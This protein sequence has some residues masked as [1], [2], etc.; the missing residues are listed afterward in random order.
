[1]AKTWKP[2]KAQ[3]DMLDFVSHEMQYVRSGTREF[4]T[5]QSLEKRG[6][7][8]YYP[9]QEYSKN[10]G[11][12]GMSVWGIT[13]KGKPYVAEL[14]AFMVDF[15]A[16]QNAQPATGKVGSDADLLDEDVYIDEP[17][18]SKPLRVVT[19]DNCCDEVEAL[20]QER[21]KLLRSEDAYHV[22]NERL[23]AALFK[24]SRLIAPPGE[25]IA[26]GGDGYI[27]RVLH[28]IDE[29]LADE[30]VSGGAIDTLDKLE[31]AIVDSVRILEARACRP[32][33]VRIHPKHWYSM[34]R[35]SGNAA[36][37]FPG[38]VSVKV[39]AR[40]VR[41]FIELTQDVTEGSIDVIQRNR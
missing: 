39:G 5:M 20:I 7:V 29:A 8:K 33:H 22:E 25:L 38:A 10:G 21:D 27:M 14:V 17:V 31:R 18:N 26:M 35:D 34:T 1:M 11:V 12:R 6:L 19:V 3:Q 13:E 4:R 9:R 15:E 37:V 24:I 16:K 30:P 28:I 32:T 2:S 40:D 36:H 41:L 23:R